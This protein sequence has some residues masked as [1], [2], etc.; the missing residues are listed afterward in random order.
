MLLFDI[1]QVLCY[2]V[3][4]LYAWYI[5]Q[6]AAERWKDLQEQVNARGNDPLLYIR[7]FESLAYVNFAFSAIYT[8][9]F[10]KNELL[11][12]INKLDTYARK[13][14]VSKSTFVSRL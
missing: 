5:V 12:Y 7:L 2:G 3:N 8:Q 10:K 9:T 1:L 4:I 11:Q 13:H 6:R 14:Q